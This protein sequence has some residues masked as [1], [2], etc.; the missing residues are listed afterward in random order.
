MKGIVFTPDD[1][2]YVKEFGDPL[3]KTIGAEVDGYIEV[4]H[5]RGLP[6]P[7]MM[8]VNEEGLLQKLPFNT[9]GSFLYQTALHGHPI[10]GNI[11]IAKDGFND[12]GERDITGLSDEEIFAFKLMATVFSGGAIK[13]V[14]P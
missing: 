10:V 7:Y 2:M 8:V 6:E 9:F 12:D 5:P 1:K 11:V 14:N 13:E 4:V 3:Y